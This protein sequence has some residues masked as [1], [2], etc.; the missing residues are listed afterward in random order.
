MVAELQEELILPQT[1]MTMVGKVKQY[2]L[3]FR[4]DT[5]ADV[6]FVPQSIV[7]A[8]CRSGRDIQWGFMFLRPEADIII[9]IANLQHAQTLRCVTRWDSNLE[10]GCGPRY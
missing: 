10:A 6:S 5:G 8:N 9:E 4:L 1:T 3:S 7:Q 2:S